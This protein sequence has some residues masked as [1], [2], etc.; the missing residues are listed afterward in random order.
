VFGGG[1]IYPDVLVD[2][3]A[4]TPAWLA[5][6]REQ[7]LILSWVGG[8]VSAN[9]SALNSLEAFLRAAALPPAALSDFRA[10]AGRQ[11]VQVPGDAGS[12]AVLQRVLTTAVARAKWGDPGSYGALAFLDPEVSAAVGSFDRAAA[13]LPAGR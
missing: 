5:R 1:G 4:S 9:A 7:D 6:V 2:E 13:I 11:G 10:F 3:A 12:E 8:Y